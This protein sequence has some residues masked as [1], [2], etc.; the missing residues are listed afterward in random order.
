MYIHIH[1]YDK[2]RYFNLT[3]T[4]KQ[5]E[6]DFQCYIWCKNTIMLTCYLC[7]KKKKKTCYLGADMSIARHKICTNDQAT[8]HIVKK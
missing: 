3:Y 8:P 1:I 2:G 6:C 4:K 7:F 5:K